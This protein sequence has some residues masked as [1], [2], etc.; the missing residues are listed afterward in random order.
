LYGVNN[1][2]SSYTVNAG[3][4]RQILNKL[5]TLKLTVMDIFNTDRV[6][7]Y[8]IYQNINLSENS[9]RDTRI[10]RLNF[11]YRFGKSTVKSAAKRNTGNDDERRRTGN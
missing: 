10:V 6:R 4:S 7:N 1:L 9:K 11:S 3:I 2:K 8:A 5:G